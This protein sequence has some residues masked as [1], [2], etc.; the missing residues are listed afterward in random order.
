MLTP[1]QQ[2]ELDERGLVTIDP[3]FPAALV[4]EASAALARL[5]P[6]ERDEP[7]R[8]RTNDCPEAAIEE[9]VLS[10]AVEEAAMAALRAPT[11]A[12]YEVALVRVFPCP[13]PFSFWEH[14]DAKYEASRYATA[15]RQ[16]G[17]AVIL[18]LTDVDRDTGPMMV[19]PGSHR[20]LAE[21]WERHPQATLHGCP[22][23]ELPALPYADPEPILAR[24]GQATIAF[25]SAIHGGSIAIGTHDRRSV[26]IGFT[27]PG[28]ELG[29]DHDEQR[30]R[31]AAGLEARRPRQA[32]PTG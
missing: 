9:L 10:P 2:R 4:E 3:G 23:A 18:W 25:T 29:L 8:H 16:L 13:G 31:Y 22:L 1:G 24:R 14:I 17:V 21:H 6:R 27:P 5:V 28:L 15:P 30:Q 19:R 12:L 32:Q 7:R 11:V 26:H 20:L